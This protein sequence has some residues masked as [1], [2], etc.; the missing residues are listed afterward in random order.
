[1]KQEKIKSSEKEKRKKAKINAHIFSKKAS[2]YV[3][4]SYTT[5]WC[6]KTLIFFSFLS[7]DSNGNPVPIYGQEEKDAYVIN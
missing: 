7:V 3:L 1:M 5:L 6:T 4:H 2:Q